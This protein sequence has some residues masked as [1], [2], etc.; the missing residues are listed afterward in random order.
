MKVVCKLVM[1]ALL[2]PS[3]GHALVQVGLE[4]IFQEE[5]KKKPAQKNL[6]FHFPCISD[7]RIYFVTHRSFPFNV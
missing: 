1:V 7:G 3:M 5:K 2:F 4:R 6:G